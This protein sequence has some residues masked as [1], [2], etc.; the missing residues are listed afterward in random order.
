[1]KVQVKFAVW[2][3]SLAFGAG[4]IAAEIENPAGDVSVPAGETLT[5]RGAL[6]PQGAVTVAEASVLDLQA[7]SAGAV[8]TLPDDLRDGLVLWMDGSTN[9]KTDDGGKVVEWRDVRDSA[10]AE[11]SACVY[12][13][14]VFEKDFYDYFDSVAPSVSS[15]LQRNFIDFGEFGSSSWMPF[16]GA[17]TAAHAAKRLTVLSF[18]AVLRPHPTNKIPVGQLLGDTDRNNIYSYSGA[19]RWVY[20]QNN[21]QGLLTNA[22]TRI[23]GLVVSSDGSVARGAI[24]PEDGGKVHLLAQIGSGGAALASKCT[25]DNFGNYMGYHADDK[26]TG[27]SGAKYENGDRVGGPCIGEILLFNRCVTDVERRRIEAYLMNKWF[28]SPKLGSTDVA[29]GGKVAV[30]VTEDAALTDISGVGAVEKDGT[31]SLTLIRNSGIF[32]GV[33]TLKQGSLKVEQNQALPPF[34]AQAGQNLV[35]NGGTVAAS[36]GDAGVFSARGDGVLALG[37]VAEDVRQIKVSGAEL[38]FRSS[39]TWEDAASLCPGFFALTN[40]LSNGGF[41]DPKLSGTAST[42]T[43]PTGWSYQGN[44]NYIGMVRSDD[45]TYHKEEHTGPVPEGSQFLFL[46][47]KSSGVTANGAVWRTFTVSQRGVYAVRLWHSARD[48]STG[49]YP[50]RMQIEID[51]TNIVDFTVGF[52]TRVTGAEPTAVKPSNLSKTLMSRFLEYEFQTPTLE[53]GEHTV[54]VKEIVTTA[55]EAGACVGFFDDIRIL[56]RQT[57]RQVW[58]PNSSFDS[59]SQIGVF[60]EST[61]SRYSMFIEKPGNADWT[62]ETVDGSIASSTAGITQDGYYWYW[63]GRTNEWTRFSDYRKAYLL[64]SAR[65]SNEIVIPETGDYTFSVRYSKTDWGVGA[66]DHSCSVSLRNTTTGESIDLGKFWPKTADTAFYSKSFCAVAGT[67]VLALQNTDLPEGT[68]EGINGRGTVVDDVTIAFGGETVWTPVEFQR[69]FAAV[70]ITRAEEIAVKVN[71]ETAGVYRIVAT[72]AGQET[73][74]LTIAGPTH[75]FNFYPHVLNVK[76]D[77]ETIGRVSV[78]E[79]EP[80]AFAF[81]TPFAAKGEHTVSFASDAEAS[82]P[83]AQSTLKGIGFDFLSDEVSPSVD[84]SNAKICLEDDAKLILD[85]DGELSVR[86]VK[87]GSTVLKGVLSAETAPGLV[88]GRGRMNIKPNGLVILF[89]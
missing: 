68:G 72:L 64:N 82:A 5:V 41:E 37:T 54:L 80:V 83:F 19:Q 49:C 76:I 1:M 44:K 26:G 24:W 16:K 46:A 58:I 45:T 34:S 17:D 4:V 62:F 60:Q 6:A 32:D 50:S 12:P 67:Y 3:A 61:G 10:L 77:G 35:A 8:H 2:L 52:D 47:D 7:A 38:A 86:G 40:E 85:Y 84:L 65:I 27:K 69:R 36:S 55:T 13:R 22:E 29:T 21:A 59:A 23:D 88:T 51:G 73:D 39:G 30:S 70:P 57:G 14:A 79:L 71:L 31:G 63:E 81:R 66:G 74:P 89:R 20:T 9:V 18:F 33:V 43:Y 15:Y 78:D 42:T 25:A 48:T 87:S 56:P 75:G 11:A 53:A 28:A